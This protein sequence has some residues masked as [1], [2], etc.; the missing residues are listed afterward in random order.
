MGGKSGNVEMSCKGCGKCCHKSVCFGP[1]DLNRE[2]RLQ[3]FLVGVQDVDNP[4]TWGYMIEMK[5]PFVIR[6]LKGR[7]CPF[8]VSGNEC[9]I[10]ET[11]PQMCRDFVCKK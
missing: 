6:E 1:E 9:L 10:Y 11:R 5:L 4:K 2:P 8:L 7:P 3:D